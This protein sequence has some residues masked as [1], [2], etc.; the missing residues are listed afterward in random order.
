WSWLAWVKS[1][2]PVPLSHCQQKRGGGGIGIK[3]K[4][5]T[6]T[7][8]IHLRVSSYLSTEAIGSFCPILSPKTPRKY[9][10]PLHLTSLVTCVV[11]SVVTSTPRAYYQ[12]LRHWRHFA[13][14][15]DTERTERP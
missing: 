15:G 14:S 6:T 5:L 9:M 13:L 4:L 10:N 7:I 11:T 8:Y 2:G 12:S 3:N 1:S